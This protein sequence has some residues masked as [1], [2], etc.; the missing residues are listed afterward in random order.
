MSNLKDTKLLLKECTAG[1]KMATE[2][3]DEV[4]DFAKDPDLKDILSRSRKEHDILDHKLKASV[5]AYHTED[6]DPNPFA[7]GMSWMKTNMKLAMNN[8]DDDKTI[9]DLITDGC[10]MGIKSLRRYLNQYPTA[11]DSIKD[12]TNELI[13]IE[14][15]LLMEVA[16]YL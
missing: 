6:K 14:E 16:G 12:I 9:A 13:G 10:N 5:T 8:G 11:D 1:V 15:D 2:A 4:I 7:K 3:I